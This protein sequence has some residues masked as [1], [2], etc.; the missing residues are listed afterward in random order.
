MKGGGG[1]LPAESG[2]HIGL[3]KFCCNKSVNFAGKIF[4]FC[5]EFVQFH[6]K[7]FGFRAEFVENPVLPFDLG[8][9]S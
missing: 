5:I 7:F 1:G 4:Q 2:I 8:S 3:H 6:V 9:K